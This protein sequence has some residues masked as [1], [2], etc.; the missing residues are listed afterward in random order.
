MEGL[1][2]NTERQRAEMKFEGWNFV[3]LMRI[4]M[5]EEEVVEGQTVK[6]EEVV[7]G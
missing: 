6:A 2:R 5:C 7:G 3:V 1:Y 4:A